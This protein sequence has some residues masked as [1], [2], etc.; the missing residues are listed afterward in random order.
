M[1]NKYTNILVPVDGSDQAI[2][3]LKEAVEVAKRNKAK[4]WIM[5]A[6]DNSLFAADAKMIEY[7]LEQEDISSKNILRDAE[8]LIPESV[9]CEFIAVRGN[10]KGAII[11]QS[12][13]VHAD[14]IIMGAT[15]KGAIERVLV[16]S[17]T[18]YVVNHAPCNVMVVR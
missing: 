6:T 10:H 11:N 4:L 3:A 18:A 5:T 2:H 14:L 13:E 16:G 17:T 12:K 8:K 1:K 9:V 7:F 15:G